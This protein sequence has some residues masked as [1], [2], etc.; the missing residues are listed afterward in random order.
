MRPNTILLST[1]KLWPQGEQCVPSFIAHHVQLHRAIAL[2]IISRCRT[3]IR[4]V[5]VVVRVCAI[6]GCAICNAVRNAMVNGPFASIANVRKP[7]VTRHQVRR[8]NAR[9]HF[10]IPSTTD[11]PPAKAIRDLEMRNSW[12]QL[13]MLQV[14][15][16]LTMQVVT[17]PNSS[18]MK[19][20]DLM[21]RQVIMAIRLLKLESWCTK[22]VQN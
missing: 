4:A 6:L 12:R 19:V 21:M 9:K 5:L 20:M 18:W 15:I 7:F 14:T 22:R 3:L 1:T 17:R 2:V 11:K 8:H 16:V 10:L 13:L